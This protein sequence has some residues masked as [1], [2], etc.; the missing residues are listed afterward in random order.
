MRPSSSW[1]EGHT[2]RRLSEG[3]IN[4]GYGVYGRPMRSRESE[5]RQ[6]QSHLGDAE[7]ERMRRLTRSK[8]SMT[9]RVSF[10]RIPRSVLSPYSNMQRNF[11]ISSSEC[12]SNWASSSNVEMLGLAFSKKSTNVDTGG[13]SATSLANEDCKISQSWSESPSPFPFGGLDGRLPSVILFITAAE[14]SHSENGTC[15]VNT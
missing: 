8:T 9:T 12:A 11:L 5:T 2:G 6:S 4:I 3:R 14:A 10:S 7:G 13:L 15:P 1:V